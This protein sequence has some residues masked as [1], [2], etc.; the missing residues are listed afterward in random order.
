MKD[1]E[2]LI[3]IH[4]RLN[5]VADDSEFVTHMHRL[6]EIIHLIPKGQH[7]T[8][9]IATRVSMD[10]LDEIRAAERAAK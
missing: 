8:G 1:R 7:L 10:V 2:F 4:Q 5:K 9:K 6:R 3:W